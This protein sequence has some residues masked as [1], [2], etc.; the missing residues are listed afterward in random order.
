MVQLKLITQIIQKP[1]ER[2]TKARKTPG[3]YSMYMN[4]FNYPNND[5]V[6]EFLLPPVN[7]SNLNNAS[8]TFDVAYAL[9]SVTGFSDTLE[10]YVQAGCDAPWEQV[11]KKFNPQLQTAPVT[12]VDFKPTQAQWRRDSIL[13][14]AYKNENLTVKFVGKCDYENN[15]YI[16]NISIKGGTSTGLTLDLLNTSDFQIFPNPTK[17]NYFVFF[18]SDKSQEVL[19]S[20]RDITGKLLME[21]SV[22]VNMGNNDIEMTNKQLPAGNVFITLTNGT[23]TGTRKLMVF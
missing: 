21:K 19:I 1:G 14:D 5:Q 10:V 16:D 7:T 15:L 9:Q 20:V 12:T 13:L 2:T 22:S 4:Y 11:Y 18:N 17:G 23:Q 8:I 3:S 6:D